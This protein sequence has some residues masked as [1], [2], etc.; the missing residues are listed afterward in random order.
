M[1]DT[2]AHC[3]ELLDQLTPLKTDCGQLCLGAC[4]QSQQGEETGMLLFAG[5]DAYY[6]NVPGY[7]LRD[8]AMGP[9]LVCSG[10]CQRANRPLSCRIFPLL[11]VVRGG[12]IK[13][14]MDARA[15]AVCPLHRQG[16]SA[17]HQ[18]FVEAVRTCGQ[19]L[20]ADEQ[21]RPLLE[22][23]TREHDELKALQ[24]AFAGR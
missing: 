17:L 13:I 12:E 14:A 7:H 2:I 20:Y 24:R 5:E 22:R 21:H 23:L 8:T 9:M 3:R 19:L 16:V 18:P 1:S 6:R 11:P 15:K 10:T 4:C